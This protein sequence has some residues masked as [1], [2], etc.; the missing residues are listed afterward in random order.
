MSIGTASNTD[1]QFE[2]RSVFA[3]AAPDAQR[4]YAA[5]DAGV[6]MLR[7]GRAKP[8]WNRIA[9]QFAEVPLLAIA[10]AGDS[11][12]IGA[13]G[14]I[15]VSHDQGASWGL[16]KLPIR[17]SVQALAATPDGGV[18]LAATEHDGVLRSTDGGANFHAWNF[19]LLDLN[20]NALALSPNF[21]SDGQALAASDHA[22]WLSRNGGRA[23]RELSIDA[24]AA[25]FT[26][27]AFGAE[28][29]LVA[30]TEEAGLW[31][32]PAPD[33]AFARETG[34]KPDTV[35]ALS[36]ALAASTAGVYRHT[37]RTWKRISPLNTA[38]SLAQCGEA[39]LAGGAGVGVA[40]I[41]TTPPT[42]ATPARRAD[43]SR[44]A[45]RDRAAGRN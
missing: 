36:G 6:W 27:V 42:A 16:C 21:A 2:T 11:V 17:A 34:F 41:S 25:P 7:T 14:D 22:V 40:V 31:A 9:P 30:G 8:V 44:A 24:A 19:G 13:S 26:A 45:D 43:E 38:L 4:C 35:N 15:A 20:I 18:V 23:W 3:L 10:A 28:G 29:A 12:W 37:G 32:A 39:V 33:A 5:T 1:T